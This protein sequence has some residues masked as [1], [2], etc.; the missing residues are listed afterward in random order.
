MI[1]EGTGRRLAAAVIIMLCA[2]GLAMPAAAQDKT[3]WRHAIIQAK[4]DAGIFMMVK[5]GFAQ[6]QGLN[7]DL[8]QVKNDVIALQA[9]ISG[10]VDSY[11]G[12]P[13][14][15]IL[16][17][18][19][20]ADVKLLGCEWPTVPYIVFA[21]PDIKTPQDL[22][23]KVFAISAPGANPAVVA[24]AVLAKYGI[25]DAAV[26]FASLGADLDR[27]KAVVA[28]VAQATVVSNEYL[29]V[30]A[31]EGV[32]VLVRA[33]TVVPDFMRVC[34]FT[35]AS[36]LKTRRDQAA[37]FLAAEMSALRYV[38]GHRD[39]E[40]ALTHAIIHDKPDDPRPAFMYDDAVRNHSIDPDINIHRAKLQWM[41]AELVK[42]G[43]LTHPYDVDQMIDAGPRQKALQLIGK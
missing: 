38:L 13:A 42:S 15:A 43:N 17:A 11:D 21:R 24:R 27:F 36:V 10:E 6:K 40:I 32:K 18:A 31:K 8:V 20:G 30:A 7:L 1:G 29:P 37:R 25:P 34:I 41:E 23:G 35:T 39:A 3:S 19:R 26:K 4:S 2:V 22:R 33:S 16:A 9:L 5:Q 14:A 28:G 12:S